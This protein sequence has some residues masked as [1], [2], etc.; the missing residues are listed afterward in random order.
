ML[1]RR[2]RR[3]MHRQASGALVDA[4][5]KHIRRGARSWEMIVRSLRRAEMVPL[6]AK[7]ADA[8]T[9][10]ELMEVV[11]GVAAAGTPHAA[12][13]LLR[14]LKMALSWAVG[15]G[16]L[17]A[18]PLDKARAPVKPTERDRVLAHKELAAVW[19]GCGSLPDPWRSMVRMLILT[20]QRRTEVAGMRWEEVDLDAALWTIP[21]ER[22]KKDRPHSVPLAPAAM[23]ILRE[24]ANHGAEGFVFTTT[25]G[26]SASSNFNK[27]KA[28]LDAACGVAEWVFHDL[29]RTVRS[30]LAALGVPREV[31]RAV[32]NHADG[33]I[34]R[35]YNRHDYLAEKREALVSMV[36]A[37]TASVGDSSIID[38]EGL[39]KAWSGLSEAAKLKNPDLLLETLEQYY[40]YPRHAALD[41]SSREL[42]GICDVVDPLVD[43]LYSV[44]KELSEVVKSLSDDD[45]TLSYL[46]SA[47]CP[48]G[49]RSSRL[50]Q[51]SA[52][53]SFGREDDGTAYTTGAANLCSK[54]YGRITDKSF[55]FRNMYTSFWMMRRGRSPQAPYVKA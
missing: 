2:R 9:R 52:R 49:S 41:L 26:R 20:G 42:N 45:D 3:Q 13:N 25:G 27:M 21:R 14:H 48:R 34:D 47:R 29:R 40:E 43:K 8:V 10:R 12:G 32:V 30:G 44:S 23:A 55:D 28:K 53:R 22:V 50:L 18:S 19:K 54:V 15:R 51:R 36:D 1:Q 5:E 17:V 24:L 46:L 6:H 37:H 31:A 39:L 35:V 38:R 11:D 4:Y 33:K 16:L 7:R